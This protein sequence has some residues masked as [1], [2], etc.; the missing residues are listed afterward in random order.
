ML[1]VVSFVLL[2]LLALLGFIV[3]VLPWLLPRPGLDGQIPEQPFADSQFEIIDG[4]RLHFR[5]RLAEPADRPLVVLLHGFGGSTFSWNA[6]LDALEQAGY[7]V[8]AVDLP[9]FGYSERRGTGLAW[10]ALVSGLVEQVAPGTERVWVGHSMG[11][12][13]AA[14]LAANQPDSSS[15]LV[16]VAGTP[17][18]RDRSGRLSPGLIG[19]VP[20]LGRWVEVIAAHRLIDEDNIRN[21]LASAFGRAPTDDEFRGY[22][23][24]LSIPGTYPALLRRFGTE[25]ELSSTGWQMV[26]TTLIWGSEDRWVPLEVGERLQAAYPELPLRLIDQTGHNPMETE[27]E[28]FQAILLELL[29]PDPG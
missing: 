29:N 24:P 11:A 14:T 4:T 20:A 6:T 21:M 9:P 13:V 2:G 16:I 1:R 19:A 22:F 3:L 26:P 17:E 18:P 10:A 25:A 12:S 8:I 28:R 15:H 7:P 27:P 23:H 5:A